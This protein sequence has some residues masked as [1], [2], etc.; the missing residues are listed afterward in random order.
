MEKRN[1]SRC[2]RLAEELAVMRSLTVG[3]LTTCT[4]LRMRVSRG[5]LIKVEKNHYSVPT[6]L[7]GHMVNI[8]VYEWQLEVCYGRQ[9]V[10]YV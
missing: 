7:I 4:S 5:S 8:Y 2:E 3:P 6:S 1:H 10:R 9:L